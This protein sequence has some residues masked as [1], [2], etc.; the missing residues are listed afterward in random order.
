M[1]FAVADTILKKLGPLAV[2]QAGLLWGLK[3]EV[4]K[5]KSTVTS[6]RAVLLDAEEQS[7]L[8]HQ[9]QVWLDE[10]KQVLYDADDLLDDFNTEALLRQQQMDIHGNRCT[11]EVSLFFSGSNPLF[12]GLWM[13]HRIK[14]IRIKLDEIDQNR[15]KFNL[16]TR[17][18]E[19]AAAMSNLGRQTDSF[20]PNVFVGRKEDGDKIISLLLSSSNEQKLEVIPIL[21]IGGLGK[22]ALTQCVYNDKSVTSHFQLKT[23]LCVSNNFNE[24]VLV[25]KMLESLTGGKVE[26]LQ[27]QTLKSNLKKQMDNKKFLLVLDDV[28]D[29]GDYESNWDRFMNFL[30]NV[31]A[32]GSKIIVTTRIGSVASLMATKGIKPHELKGLSRQE[33]WSLFEQIT[34]K[35]EVVEGGQRFKQIGEE[36]VER[37]VGVPLAI[38]AMAGILSSKRDIVDWE[39]LRDKQARLDRVDSDKRILATLRLSYDNLPSHLK[40]CFAYCSL[41]PKDCEIDVR[42][43]VQLWMGQGYIDCSQSS[44]SNLYDTGVEY[45]KSMLSKSFFQES[46]L[47]QLGDLDVCKM[48]DLMHDLALEVAGKEN[49]TLRASN[50]MVNDD[51]NFDRL[52]HLSIDFE[53]ILRESWKVPGLLLKPTKLRTFLTTNLHWRGMNAHGGTQYETIFSNMTGLRVLSFCGARIEI[54]PPCINKLKRLRYLDLSDNEMEMLPDEITRLVNLQVLIL[55]DCG[56]LQELPRDIVM[57]SYLQ[58][59]SLI[60]CNALR[61]LPSGI[62]KLIRLKEL[63]T[64][65]VTS[66]VHS[67]WGAAAAAKICDLKDLNL[68]GRLAIT[69]LESVETLEA[70]AA[71]LKRKQYLQALEL[72]W[73]E[74]SQEANAAGNLR[75]L[76]AL[77]PH[78]NLK[79]LMLSGYSGW[80]LP[81][82]FSNSLKNNVVIIRLECCVGLQYLPSLG[83]LVS[84]EE[85]TLHFLTHLEYIQQDEAFAAPL[86][87]TCNNNNNIVQ[88]LPRLK[89]LSITG[90][91]NLI[92]WW[93][94]T[95]IEVP[96]FPCLSSLDISYSEKLVSIPRLSVH[97][98]TVGLSSVKSELLGEFAAS[99]PPPHCST[100]S[101]FKSLRIEWLEGQRMLVPELLSQLVSLEYLCIQFCPNLMTLSPPPADIPSQQNVTC[102]QSVTNNNMAP[103]YALP[104]LLRFEINS[105]HSLECLPDWLQHSSKLQLLDVTFCDDLV[106]LPEWLP[107]LTAL[108]NLEVHSCAR[109]SPRLES[110]MAEDWPKV[111]R[112]PNIKINGRMVQRNGNYLAVEEEEEQEDQYQEQEAEGEEDDQELP[113]GTQFSRML[114]NCITRLTCNM[115]HRCFLC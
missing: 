76:E 102:L 39:A 114:S 74:S 87:S 47:N 20:V 5:L 49:F 93:S 28:W 59:L 48:H 83:P 101:R 105:L 18:E 73:K 12:S 112:I 99:L 65:I 15:T 103:L 104:A 78:E 111:A 34:F 6:I 96:L 91:S 92:S 13:A 9:V 26:D 21:G 79:E 30:W 32:V 22:T 84:L 110:R 88:Y 27:L 106:C 52:L 57:L 8:N 60:G 95:K 38:K 108:E 25:K 2:E 36:I 53:E 56:L 19:P 89:S 75:T 113:T 72:K 58:C 67:E 24:T 86:A 66:A 81:T 29:N 35:R 4:L 23:W 61:G 68:S 97:V 80:S 44:S 55:D 69:N 16:Q 11:S 115:F 51:I 94:T 45:F 17:L 64:F 90:C 98:E 1:A 31:G 50:S 3:S 77:E 82:W 43:L 42:M 37:C 63:S 41:F 70:E 109:L 85:L 100:Q 107:K 54:V 33:S 62:G 71:S 10:L 40:P 14:A 46:S 7:G